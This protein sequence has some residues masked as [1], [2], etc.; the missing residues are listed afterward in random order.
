MTKPTE[1]NFIFQP[2]DDNAD[3]VFVEVHD[4][5]QNSVKVGTWAADGDY[6]QL[7]ITLGDFEPAKPTVWS[8]P[9][10][11]ERPEGFECLVWHRGRWRHV[12]WVRNHEMW[13]FGYGSPGIANELGRI[14]APL[15]H[16]M[17]GD[18]WDGE[19]S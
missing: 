16:E 4:Q 14:F 1:L 13:M 3:L 10:I 12:R 5:N 9:P 7:T 15:P 2:R 18:F 8:P 17:D 6:E 11:K 19:R